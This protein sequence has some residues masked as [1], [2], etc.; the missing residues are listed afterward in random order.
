MGRRIAPGN[1]LRHR[2]EF[3]PRTNHGLMPWFY[4]A[5]ETVQGRWECRHGAW[6]F[7]DH[8]TLKRLLVTFVGSLPM[9]RQVCRSL[10]TPLMA[11]SKREHRVGLGKIPG[12]LGDLREPAAPHRSW[13]GLNNEAHSPAPRPECSVEH[14][15]AW[16]RRK[17][18]ESATQAPAIVAHGRSTRKRR[19][20]M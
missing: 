5:I 15:D 10:S 3:E 11:R 19:T 20:W 7:D 16:P 6:V 12:V 18:R 9:S 13:W 17:T 14:G 4:R 8:A 1:D 2:R